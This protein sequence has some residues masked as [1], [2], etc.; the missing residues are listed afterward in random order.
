M[1]AKQEGEH[2]S[3][4]LHVKK[5]CGFFFQMIQILQ[6][7]LDLEMMKILVKFHFSSSLE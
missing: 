1:E 5:D 7:L 2:I 6:S 4:L 3:D